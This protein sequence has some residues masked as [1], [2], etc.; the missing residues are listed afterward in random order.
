MIF[1]TH[2]HYD[3]EAYDDD[4]DALIE[5]LR[6][7]GVGLI[8]NACADI[9]GLKSGAELAKKYP[10]IY[11]S[12]GVH[13]Q[14]AANM[15]ESDLELIRQAAKNPKTR[16][17]G[18]I[19]LD[20]HYDNT[21]R[22]IQKKWFLKQ[23]EL[24]KELSLPVMIHDRDAHKDTME[25]LRY[26]KNEGGVFH[27]FSGSVEMARE[28]LDMD[29]YIAIGGSV[30]FKNAKTPKEVAAY[31]PSDRLVIETDSPYLTP[32]PHRGKRNNSLYLRFVIDTIAELR[33][34]KPE[35]I[36]RITYENGK[37]LFNIE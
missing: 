9:G 5:E 4:R 30:T 29:M 19:G 18:E 22:E 15:V 23:A 36:E 8:M 11:L 24:A 7:G 16:A 25:I 31:V 20:Y 33:G 3:D 1:D 12:A 10:Y 28:A 26:I 32:T 37:R 13:P 35:E 17:I 21:D 2:A 6:A 14:D 34:E 27:C